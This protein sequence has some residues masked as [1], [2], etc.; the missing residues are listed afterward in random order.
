MTSLPSL[1][2]DPGDGIQ[3]VKS[4]VSLRYNDKYVVN[5]DF[6]DVGKQILYAFIWV[7]LFQRI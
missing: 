5:Y 2:V 6:S 1:V 7:N 3:P 4:E